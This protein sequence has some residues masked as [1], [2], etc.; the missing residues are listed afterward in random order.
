VATTRTV[1][2][3]DPGLTGALAWLTLHPNGA[4]DLLHVADVPTVQARQGKTIKAH[5]SPAL[6]ADMMQNPCW[7][8]LEMVVIEEV[9]AMPKQGVTSVFR[10]GQ[11][12]GLISG[13]AAGLRL[14][15]AYIRPMEWQPVARI[16]RAAGDDAGRLRATQLF[17]KQSQLFARK[18]DHNRA[19]AVLIGFAYLRK[20]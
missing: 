10:F 19:D 20:L 8:A 18:M 9:F 6:L 12:A 11:V 14:P 13:V 17:P 15:I 1:L 7:P 16:S 3:I 4:I 5:I 2:A